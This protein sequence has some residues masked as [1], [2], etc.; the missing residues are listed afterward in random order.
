MEKAVLGGEILLTLVRARWV[1]AR[2]DLRSGLG[3]LRRT[4][5]ATTSLPPE[6]A[7]AVSLRLG[8]AVWR[9]LS[10]VPLDATCLARS[11]ALSAILARRGIDSQ[12]VI[13]VKTDAGFAA[14]AWVERDGWPLLP[15]DGYERLH[16][17]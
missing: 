1:M 7:M 14:H 12:L 17:L 3:T 13:G 2:L 6:D 5:V 15:H 11:L 10:A 9:T 16:A 4:Q 8:Y